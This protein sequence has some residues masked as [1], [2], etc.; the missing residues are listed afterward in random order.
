MRKQQKGFSLIEL[1]VVVA[2]MLV[3]AAIAIPAAIASSQSGNESAAASNMRAVIT[4]ETA[5][6]KLYNSGYSTATTLAPLD[7]SGTCPNVPAAPTAGAPP[8]AGA[9]LL[10]SGIAD[11]MGT[12]NAISGYV[13]TYAGTANGYTLIAVP[14][15]NVRGRKSFCADNSGS[16]VYSWG[17]TAPAPTNGACPQPA[18]GGPYALGS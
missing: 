18:T 12:A 1:L 11:N 5:Y 7:M 6:D 8:T 15:T 2:I 10:A 13:F 9:C 14:A 17:L 3:V 4:A 16:I